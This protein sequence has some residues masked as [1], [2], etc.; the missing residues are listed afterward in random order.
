MVSFQPFPMGED[1]KDKRPLTLPFF[2]TKPSGPLWT[3]SFCPYFPSFSF[4]ELVLR[5]PILTNPEP[6]VAALPLGMLVPNG[7]RGAQSPP[8]HHRIRPNMGMWKWHGDMQVMTCVSNCLRVAGFSDGPRN[9]ELLRTFLFLFSCFFFPGHVPIWPGEQ[10]ASAALCAG[11]SVLSGP[12][13]GRACSSF[14]LRFLLSVK[15]AG[16]W[17]LYP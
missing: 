9:S 1:P 13:K 15:E 14:L 7:H 4:P 10:K 3:C 5:P 2:R 11:G 8:E 6:C 16:G 17:Y 12:Y